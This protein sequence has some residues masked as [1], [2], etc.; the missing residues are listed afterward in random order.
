ME[1]I[2]FAA[3][4]ST[5][6]PHRAPALGAH[7]ILAG[8]LLVELALLSTGYALDRPLVGVVVSLAWAFFLFAFRFPDLAW[9]LIWVAFPFST[10]HMMG[11]G[12][13]I[14]L[15]TEPMIGLALAAWVARALWTGGAELPRSPMHLPLATLALVALVSASL[16]QY[17]VVG[18]KAWVVAAGYTAFGYLY[19]LCAPC[20]RVRSERWTQL[21][22]FSAAA[23]GLFGAIRVL[24]A[25]AS[26]Q[27]AYGAA[28]PFFREH[29]SYSAFLAMALPLALLLTLARRGRDRFGYVLAACS[30]S[31]GVVF[32]FTR[33]AWVSLAVVLPMMFLM[34]GRSRRSLK[35]LI[36]PTALALLIVAIVLAAGATGSLTSH[37]ESVTDTENVSNLERLNRWMAAVEM[38]KDRPIL[39]V[40]YGSYSDIYPQYRRKLIVTEV[41][42]Q[43]MGAHSEPLRLLSETGWIGFAAGIWF[44]GTAAW[45]GFR[46][47][48]TGD[49][50]TRL[51]ALGILA[52]LGTYAIHG[53][54]NAYL[55]NDKVTIPFWSGLGV[56]A[57]L[58]RQGIRSK[59][60]P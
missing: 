46:V 1:R 6:A 49:P 28:R 4:G 15:P 21:A 45:V 37:A 54:F 25:G 59:V 40:G 24:S 10:E 53:I 16:G 51:L 32:S 26:L 8:V 17:P 41:A 47:I 60:G 43:R 56:L 34:W 42:Q 22:I 38:V 29:G 5:S 44:L 9:G 19:F 31:L 20:D 58:G 36:L 23:W 7:G 3:A 11:S 30:I 18:F 27:T 39:G 2:G 35:P 12:T 48:R 50:D 13:A 14:L 33:A 55:G 52:G 57:A